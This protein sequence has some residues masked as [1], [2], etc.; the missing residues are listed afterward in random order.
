MLCRPLPPVR[1]SV[2]V[3]RCSR[4]PPSNLGCCQMLT[5]QPLL[6]KSMA[7][8]DPGT[9]VGYWGRAALAMAAAQGLYHHLPRPLPS[10]TSQAKGSSAQPSCSPLRLSVPPS[11][12]QRR[13]R[14]FAALYL[15]QRLKAADATP[16][17][18]DDFPPSCAPP[19][20]LLLP[21]SSCRWASYLTNLDRSSHHR[22]HNR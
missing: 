22:R 19:P 12:T 11:V 21:P 8:A 14:P 13:Q 17:T 2:S 15:L 9:A 10:P 6:Q 5:V 18:S 20:L 7:S 1:Q 4:P 3:R 16:S